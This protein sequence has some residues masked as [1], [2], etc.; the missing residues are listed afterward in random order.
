M[1]LLPLILWP[2]L[3]KVFNYLGW[4]E[5]KDETKIKL[6]RNF[7]AFIDA[8]SCC[9]GAFL[10]YLSNNITF[11]NLLYSYLSLIIFDSYLIISKIYIKNIFIYIII[12][13]QC[14]YLSIIKVFYLIALYIIL[15]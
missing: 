14:Y 8:T 4:G 11:Y 5:M 13:L 3:Y 7:L 10:Y 6:T 2:I 9:L 12:L 15:I 1:N